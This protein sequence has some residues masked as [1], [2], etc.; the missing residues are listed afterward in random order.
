MKLY[1]LTSNKYTSNVCPVNIHF[2]NK[3]WP[4]RDITIVGYEDVLKLTNLP[5]NV[6]VHC[7]GNQDDYGKSWSNALIPYFENI[8][9]EYFTLIFDDHILMNQVD[10][11]KFKVIEEQF[12]LKQADKA[13]IG[14]GIS[15]REAT[16]LND[17]LLIFNQDANYRMSLH[18]AVWTKEYFL[19]Y[20]KPDMT[21]WDFE[22]GNNSRAM[23]DGATIINYRYDYPNEP[24]IFSYL[25]LYTKGQINI[26]SSSITSNQ[27]SARYFETEDIQYI[28]KEVKE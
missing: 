8:P 1:L 19:R 16:K 24:H 10:E 6:E 27:P 13:M 4:D 15:L 21:S 7:L 5:S 12:K 17:N 20:L 28:W 3:Y 22:L 14:G 23:L 26:D 9:E 25:E 18:P 2:L 11:E